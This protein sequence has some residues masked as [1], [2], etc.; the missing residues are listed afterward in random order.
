MFVYAVGHM[1]VP[2][3]QLV[4]WTQALHKEHMMQ[5]PQADNISDEN[6]SEAKENKPN[7]RKLGATEHHEKEENE[8]KNL[9]NKF[10][11]HLGLDI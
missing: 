4:L 3:C 2:L 5:Q 7:S 8:Y 11:L 6:P 1:K 10:K 9:E